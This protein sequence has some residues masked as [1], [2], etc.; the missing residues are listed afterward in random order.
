MQIM[1]IWMY[2]SIDVINGVGG[3][4]IVPSL[5]LEITT[6]TTTTTTTTIFT[7]AAAAA[8][9]VPLYK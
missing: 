1:S 5:Q 4:L 6:T 2:M 3:T 8:V 7:T 9:G